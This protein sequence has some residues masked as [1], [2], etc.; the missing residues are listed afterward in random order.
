MKAVAVYP[1]KP[2]SAHLRH[3]AEPSHDHVPAGRGVLVTDAAI[4][5]AISLAAVV[6]ILVLALRWGHRLSSVLSR[7]SD[8]ALLLSLFGLT[9]LAAT[10]RTAAGLCRHRR[11]PRWPSPL[12]AG[13]GPGGSADRSASRPLRRHLLPVLLLPDPSRLTR[14]R[15]RP[16]AVARHRHG[17]D[18]T[19]HR[20]VR[21]PPYRCGHCR[22]TAGGTV[23]VARGEFSIVV[24]SLGSAA[25]DGAEL[26]ALAAAYVLI[27]ATAATVVTKHVDR[28]AQ[29][30]ESLSV[31]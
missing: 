24:A 18:Q 11:L 9:L 19:R 3:M 17:R 8:E 4:T 26:R 21:G 31:D 20:L 13:A 25:A 15:H 30:R 10:C 6:A 7:G 14:R 12:R 2:H 22:S 23:L 29:S 1:G 16:C 28:S 27:T 5:V